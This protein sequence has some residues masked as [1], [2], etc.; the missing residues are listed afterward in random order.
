VDPFAKDHDGRPIFKQAPALFRGNRGAFSD[1]SRSAG[2]PLQDRQVGRGAAWGDWDN[3][4]RPDLL[5]CENGGPTRL[6]R[7]ETPD[8]HHWLGVRL[9]GT[10]GNRNG[11]GAEVRAGTGTGVQRRWV[12]SGSSYLSHSDSRALFGLGVGAAE[13]LEVVWP[14]GKVTRIDRPEAD[15]YLEVPEPR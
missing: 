13:Y 15:R 4:G 3:D 10:E 11:Y 1:T 14:S 8:T 5:L 6:L 9:R 12:R 2:N 7:N